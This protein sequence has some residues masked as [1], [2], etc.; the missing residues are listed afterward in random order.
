M[1]GWPEFGLEGGV[2]QF[3]GDT[4][5]VQEHTCTL[6]MIQVLST[7]HP[8]W[9]QSRLVLTVCHCPGWRLTLAGML[10]FVSEDSFPPPSVTFVHNY[11]YF[12]F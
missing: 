2:W 1:A 6:E 3:L 5:K 10:S 7:Q 4:G 9:L 12:K 8:M 11:A